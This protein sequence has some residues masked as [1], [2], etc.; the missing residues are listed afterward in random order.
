M[1]RAIGFDVYGTLVDPI[2][3]QGELR[4]L[5]GPQAGELARLWRE[6][7]IEYSFR[8]GLMRDYVDFEVCTAQALAHAAALLGIDLAGAERDR[9]LEAYRRLEHFPEVPAALEALR[10]RGHRLFAFSNGTPSGVRAVLGHA[11]VLGLLEDVV[12]VDAVRSY[13]P[14]PAVYALL[15]ERAG[16]P[17]HETWLVSSN[18]WDVIGAKTAGLR[19]AWVR[20]SEAARLDPWGIEPDCMVADLAGLEEALA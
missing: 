6:K 2:A 14:D 18:G 4:A 17:M 5:A 10:R 15:A 16:C 9:L 3:M 8:R 13:K 11:G 1:P 20:R 19:A 12:S 7:Q